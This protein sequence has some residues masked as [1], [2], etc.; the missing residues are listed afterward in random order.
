M[1]LF[2][3]YNLRKCSG[4]NIIQAPL[5]AT[6]TFTALYSKR[7]YLFCSF[8]DKNTDD[9]AV[10]KNTDDRAVIKNTDDRAVIKNALTALFTIHII[11]F[12]EK[13]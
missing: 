2:K 1:A 10:I 7:V 3:S 6:I 9:R 12:K 8:A 5:P 4:L 13:R 11:I